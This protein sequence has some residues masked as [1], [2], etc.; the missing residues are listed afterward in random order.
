MCCATNA[1]TLLPAR[2]IGHQLKMLPYKCGHNL[3]V[4]R[5]YHR[6]RPSTADSRWPAFNV[7]VA[8]AQLLPLANYSEPGRLDCL[9][10]SHSWFACSCNSGGPARHLDVSHSGW[11][12]LKRVHLSHSLSLPVCAPPHIASLAYF[13]WKNVWT[14]LL[15]SSCWCIDQ[16]T[17]A[18]SL[19]RHWHWI[20]V[21]FCLYLSRSFSL[22][23][24]GWSSWLC[25]AYGIWHPF[26]SLK[27]HFNISTFHTSG[28][29]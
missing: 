4:L 15:L 22:T 29:A 26:W 7:F 5:Y 12:P 28:L 27:A 11:W 17:I 14:T 10:A 18:A 24:I 2:S 1:R 6:Q 16:N 21:P 25:V 19:E 3:I 20:S 23:Q 8:F 13:H 9:P